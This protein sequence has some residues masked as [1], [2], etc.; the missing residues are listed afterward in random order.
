MKAMILAAGLGTRMRPLTDHTPKPLLKAGGKPLLQYPIENLRAAGIVDIVINTAW[1]GEQIEACFGDG[2]ALGVHLHYSHEETP[3]ETAGGIVR[4]LPLLGDTPFILINGDV[5]TDFPLPRLVRRAAQWRSLPSAPSAHLVLVNNPE[6][7]PEGDFS[8]IRDASQTDET[9]AQ[10]ADPGQ[11]AV[12]QGDAPPECYTFSGVSL[13]DPALFANLAEGPRKLAPILRE[14]M[15]AKKVTGEHWQ[16]Q[17]YDIGTPA[18]LQTLDRQLS[19]ATHT[20]LTE[21]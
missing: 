17:W 10:V 5:W 3:L 8:L 14:A 13:L 11:L 12:P 20:A 15:T 6:H 1:L 21:K 19:F 9:G 7:H 2:R 4:A 16:G 18:R